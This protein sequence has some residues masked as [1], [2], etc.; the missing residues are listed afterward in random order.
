LLDEAIETNTCFTK[1]LETTAIIQMLIWIMNGFLKDK[2]EEDRTKYSSLLGSLMIALEE[3]L[4][5]DLCSERVVD[6]VAEYLYHAK[7]YMF[8][9]LHLNVPC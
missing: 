5:E 7:G 9:L 3:S 8:E 4:K 6:R 2:N 1:Q